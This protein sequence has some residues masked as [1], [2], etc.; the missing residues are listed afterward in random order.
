MSQLTKCHIIYKSKV[1]LFAD[2]TKYTIRIRLILSKYFLSYR[3]VLD[4]NINI[5]QLK[6]RKKYLYFFSFGAFIIYISQCI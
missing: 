2:I 5:C 4:R 6:L 3:D 1:Y